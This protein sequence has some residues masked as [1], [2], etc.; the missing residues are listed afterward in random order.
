MAIKQYQHKTKGRNDTTAIIY[1]LRGN[2]QVIFKNGVW[3]GD[4]D[5]VNARAKKFLQQRLEHGIIEEAV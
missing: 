3:R 5:A 4:I 2:N 1:N